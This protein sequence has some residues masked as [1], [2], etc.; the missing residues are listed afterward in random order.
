[1]KSTRLEAIDFVRGLSVIIMVCVHTL[2]MYADVATQGDSW[3]GTTVH[4][5]G[6]GTAAFLIAMG[7]SLAL[8]SRNT[9][10]LL[11]KRGVFILFAAF[12]MNFLK[13]IVPI[14]VFGTMPENFINAYGWTSPLNT[15]QHLYLLLTGDILQMAGVA[16]ILLA[17]ITAIS[18]NK[19]HFLMLAVFIAGFSQELRGFQPG[20]PG[21]NYIADLLWGA[22][23]NVYFPIFP[24]FSSIL[25]GV[26]IGR[27]YAEH[28]DSRRLYSDSLKWGVGLLIIGG[29]LV[30]AN[31]E[32]HFADF[33]HTG[34]GGIMYLTGLNLVGLW[35][36]N[37]V[38]QRLS[39]KRTFSKMHYFLTYCSRHVTVLYIIQWT[40]VCW[41]MGIIGF[42]T[43]HTGQVLVM[44]PVMLVVTLAANYSLLWMIKKLK[45]V[46]D[47]TTK[48]E[49]V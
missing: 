42:Q 15:D 37:V 33:F 12:F 10:S 27:C 5:L 20:I 41:G 23:Y 28:K 14:E 11:A 45:I 49:A 24:W 9:P 2:W 18:N 17:G 8:S 16:L 39:S 46:R 21:L 3:L 43:L 19:Y 13:F 40:L 4:F 1:M 32:Y 36:A 6:K 44:M 48:L 38:I 34:P 31:F 7:I 30:M 35:L 47:R 29:A 26:F 25:I 22:K